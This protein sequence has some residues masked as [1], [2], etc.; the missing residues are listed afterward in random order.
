MQSEM[1]YKV[2]K[3]KNYV[4]AYKIQKFEEKQKNESIAI[5]WAY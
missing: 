1:E 4:N 3:H 5:K 2:K